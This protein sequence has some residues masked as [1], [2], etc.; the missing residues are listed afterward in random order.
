MMNRIATIAVLVLG[1]SASG[2]A[3]AQTTDVRV[4]NPPDDAVNSASVA[5]T[6]PI[7]LTRSIQGPTGVQAYDISMQMDDVVPTGFRL[8]IDHITVAVTV[9]PTQRPQVSLNIGTPNNLPTARIHIPVISQLTYY[10]PTNVALW[11][12]FAGSTPAHL[13][14][15]ADQQLTAQVVRSR[16][17]GHA[18]GFITLQGH[19]VRLQTSGR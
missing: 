12:A 13:P 14:L 17:A 11:S 6:L 7:I 9:P 3:F 5:D 1:L 16:A 15:E 4:T 2:S 19:L 8:I 10:A 18:E